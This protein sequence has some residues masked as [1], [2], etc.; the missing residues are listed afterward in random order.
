MRYWL[1]VV[2]KEHVKRG[3]KGGFAQVC[4]G[5]KGPLTKLTAGD[6]F[7]YYSPKIA[8]QGK[9][10]CKEFT[11]IGRVTSGK[12]YQVEMTPS[13]HPFRVDITYFPSKDAPLLDLMNDLELTQKK[14]WGMQLLKGLLEITQSDFETIAKAMDAS[15]QSAK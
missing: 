12:V 9:E 2:S 3:V 14:S 10:P 5:K 8:F 13:F 4:H 1:G 15:L 6:G 11:A 7:I